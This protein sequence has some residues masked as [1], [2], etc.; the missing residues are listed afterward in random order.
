MFTV[1]SRQ[2]KFL[3]KSVILVRERPPCMML[4]GHLSNCTPPKT[5]KKSK[6]I[7]MFVVITNSLMIV[8]DLYKNILLIVDYKLLN[9][10][11]SWLTQ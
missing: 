3:G 9:K 10:C 7:C 1:Y 6:N 8:T 11:N 5:R 2:E 4:V